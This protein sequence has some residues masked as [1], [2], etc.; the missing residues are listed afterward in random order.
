MQ[1]RDRIKELRKV[2]A[3]SLRANASNWRLHPPEQKSALLGL[4]HEV[5][6]VDAIMARE[7]ED[8]GLE[9]IDG[10]LRADTV[11]EQEVSVLILDVTAEEA[12]KILATKD[13]LAAMATADAAKLD[14]L[15]GEV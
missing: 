4:L 7:L 2:K 8:G 11:D 5:G 15:L 13:P 9:I 1:I 6:Y 10:H 12:A 3:S 14:E